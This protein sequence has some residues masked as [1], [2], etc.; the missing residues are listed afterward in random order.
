VPSRIHRCLSEKWGHAGWARARGQSSG[1]D[2]S[3]AAAHAQC[4]AWRAGPRRASVGSRGPSADRRRRLAVGERKLRS[5]LSRGEKDDSCSH[6][7]PSPQAST[8][9]ESKTCCV[10]RGTPSGAVCEWNLAW[11]R[12]LEGRLLG[13]RHSQV[14][15]S[16]HGEGWAAC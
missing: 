11:L 13:D 16:I 10:V 8:L 12:G 1:A 9:E 6:V 7:S 5:S 4:E 15:L 3:G 2:T 14:D